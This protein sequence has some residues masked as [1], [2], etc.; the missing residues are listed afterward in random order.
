MVRS[1]CGVQLKDRKR[2]KD[3][4]LMFGLNK[5]KSVGYGK[6]S[7]LVWSCVE[8]R[9]DDHVLRKDFEKIL[10]LKVK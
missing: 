7:S 3:F 5:A 4:M 9:E 8:E 6:Q 2:S 1:I 10:R